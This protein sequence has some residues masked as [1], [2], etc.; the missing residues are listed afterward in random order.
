M[1]KDTFRTGATRIVHTRVNT[2]LADWRAL[3]LTE[4]AKLGVDPASVTALREQHAWEGGDTTAGWAQHV[5]HNNKLR[6]RTK[7]LKLLNPEKK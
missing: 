6:A 5:W 1:A 2:S 4:Y 7:E 3:V